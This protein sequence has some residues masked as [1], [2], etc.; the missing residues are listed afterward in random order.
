MEIEGTVISISHTNSLKKEN[1]LLRKRVRN[2]ED[3]LEVQRLKIVELENTVNHKQALIM[4]M[5]QDPDYYVKK[6]YKRAKLQTRPG[7]RP[8]CESSPDQPGESEKQ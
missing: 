4:R 7:W 1:E 8:P 2:L 3:T 6:K 5:G